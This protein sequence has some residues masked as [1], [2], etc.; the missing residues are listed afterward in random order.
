MENNLWV[1]NQIF[2]SQGSKMRRRREK[3]SQL[4]PRIGIVKTIGTAYHPQGNG[5][6]RE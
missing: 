1:C 5:K 3:I 2:T 6:E 4:L